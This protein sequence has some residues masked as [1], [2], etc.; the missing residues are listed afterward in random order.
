MLLLL[1]AVAS[2]ISAEE[3]SNYDLSDDGWQSFKV[4][5]GKN[6]ENPTE[7]SLRRA[8]R[9]LKIQT[10]KKHN[11]EAAQG[12]HSFTLGENE[13][14]D[15]T[16]AE[17]RK[18][19]GLKKSPVNPSARRRRQTS[20]PTMPIYGSAVPTSTLPKT[21][22][23]IT[24]GWVG[25]VQNQGQCASSWAYA[26]AAS[27]AA[28]HKNS[29]KRY[30]ELSAQNLIDCSSAQGNDGCDGG[31]ADNSFWYVQTNGI[32]SVN[33]YPNAN[34]PTNATCQYVSSES[35]T[36]INSWRDV[37]KANEAALQ[38]AVALSGPVVAMMDA[39]VPSFSMY[40]GGVYSPPNCS[41]YVTTYGVLVI[42]YGTTSSNQQYWLVQNSMGT[43]W[44]M[45]GLMMIARNKNNMCGIASDASFPVIS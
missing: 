34:G 16:P 32:D 43:S 24:S 23:W 3:S 38:Q 11:A 27:I 36:T 37:Q 35:I 29:T 19:L 44:G 13:F 17:N 4:R 45:N 33:A 31:D 6:Y 28:Q 41:P 8:I 15:W 40:A 20:E 1:S 18:M 22:N 25:P 7:D 5:F 26:S 14:T 30:I 42:G 39:S 10:I 2:T 21:V 12:Q 9:E